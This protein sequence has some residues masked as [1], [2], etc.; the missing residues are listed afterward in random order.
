[1][2][3]VTN[4]FFVDKLFLSTQMFREKKETI[5]QSRFLN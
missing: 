2:R 1:M 3:N 5:T 4:A